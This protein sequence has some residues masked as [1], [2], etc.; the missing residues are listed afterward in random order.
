MLVVDDGP[1]A[2]ADVGEVG[3]Y[4]YGVHAV[5]EGAGEAEDG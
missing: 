3:G 4:V 5:G 2:G 1:G